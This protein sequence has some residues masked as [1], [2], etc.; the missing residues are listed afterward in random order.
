MP[1]KTNKY[2]LIIVAATLFLGSTFCTVLAQ[3]TDTII[4]IDKNPE[5]ILRKIDI[6]KI[7][8]SGFNFWQDRFSGHWAGVDFGFNTFLNKDYSGY[9]SEFMNNDIF[10]SNSTYV[11]LIQQSIGLQHN[12]NTIGL[13]T[14]LGMYFQS[15][16]LD[17]NTTIELQANDVIV[18]KMLYFND[19]QKSKLSIVSL[20]VPLLAEFQIPI[21]RYENRLYI[22]GGLYLG[23]RLNSHTKI[24]YRTEQKEKLKVPG[25]FSLQDFKYGLMFRTGYRR[26]NIFAT[27]EITPLF[28]ENKGPELTPFTFGFTLLQF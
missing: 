23:Y 14:G 20:M 18:P 25:H 24:K 3:E 5:K 6:R 8:S 1:L 17:Q 4:P 27:Y 10:R 16:R 19:N 11:N 9:D 13:V 22:S 26:I 7:T 15:Y 28:K 12:R 21:Q 2:F